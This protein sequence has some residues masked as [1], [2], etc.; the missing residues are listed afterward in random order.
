M[1]S[2]GDSLRKYELHGKE[3]EQQT[4]SIFHLVIQTKNSES[5]VFLENQ[6][7]KNKNTK[8]G[9]WFQ[10]LWKILV[11]MGIFPR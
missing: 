9:W 8:T 1:K 5:E 4:Q 6:P 11:K 7:E 10:P 3:I 2:P